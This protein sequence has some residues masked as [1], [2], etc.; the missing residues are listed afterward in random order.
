MQ[1]NAL[2]KYCKLLLTPQTLRCMKITAFIILAFCLHVSATTLAQNV[3]LSERKAPLEKVIND[4]KQQTGYAFFYN[5]DWM[6]QAQPVDVDVKNTSLEKVLE[7]CFANQPFRYNVINKTIVLKL[8]SEPE[9]LVEAAPITVSGK[10]TDTTGAPLPNA[11]VTIVGQN[12]ATLTSADGTFNISAQPGD[13]VTISFVGYASNSFIVKDGM[14]YQTVVLHASENKL[15]EVA[16]TVNT[17]YQTLPKERATGSF[18]TIDNK[19][20]NEEVTTNVLDR[21]EGN[22]P[23]LQFN[24]TAAGAPNVANGINATPNI[25]IRGH[26]TLFANDQPLIVVDDFPYDGN[27]SNIN[28]NDVESITVLKDAAA[29]SI[30]GVRSGNGVIVI[31]TKKGK[32]GQKMVIQFNTNVTVGDKPNLFYSPEFLDANDYINIEQKLYASGYY[33]S[34]LSKPYNLVTPA[35]QIMANQTAGT[36]SATDATN[37]LNALRNYDV[38]NDLTKYFLQKSVAQQYALSLLGGGDNSDYSLSLGSDNDL[39]NLV[40]NS[41]GRLTLNALYN[42]YPVKNLK[43]SVGINYVQTSAITDASSFVTNPTSLY[44]YAQLA[45]ANGNPLAISTDFSPIY[46]NSM[47]SLGYL[48]WQDKPLADIALADNQTKGIDNRINLGASYTFVKG[49]SA[50]IK[51]QYEKAS[52]VANNYYSDSTYTTRSQINKFASRSATGVFTYPIPVGGILQYSNGYLTSQDARVQFNF[53]HNW[54]NNHE[55]NAIAGADIRQEINESASGIAYGYDNSTGISTTTIDYADNFPLN[56]TGSGKITNSSSFSK[57]TN[58]YISYYSNASYTYKQRYVF[59]LSGRIDYSNLFGVNTNQKVVPLFSTGFAWSLDKEKFY[60][61]DWLPYLRPRVT[62]GYNANINTSATAV[63]TISQASNSTYS[64]L[65]FARVANPGNP[66]LTWEKDR[67]VNLAVDFEIQKSVLSGSIDYYLKNGINLFANSP[68]A[69]QTG[70]TTFFGNSADTKGHGVD[71]QLNSRNIYNKDF[72][73]TTSFIFSHVIDIVTKYN[74]NSTPSS[75]FTS[76]GLTPVVGAPV[77]ALYSYKWA[78]LSHTTGDPQGYIGNQ[79]S[80]NYSAIIS[81]ATFDSLQYNGP[82][83][84]TTFGSLRN[85]FSYKQFSLSFNIF[86]EFDFYFRKGSMWSIQNVGSGSNSGVNENYAQAWQKPGDEAFTNVP[87]IQYPPFNSNRTTFY[88]NSSILVDKG[89]NIRL[90]NISLSY[91]LT[92]AQIRH[93]PFSS[94]QLYGYANNI[95]I[96]WRANKDHLDP[97]IQNQSYSIPNPMS[98]SLGL[99]VNF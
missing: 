32:R 86:Y 43:L 60:H 92:K 93:L 62:Y 91:D 95:G 33:T 48:N 27:L 38:R 81:K 88:Q 79:P 90:G 10:V 82:S 11:T 4:I 94:L 26:S 37:Q 75:Y 28:P 25:S 71:I 76:A 41:N 2:C 66:D 16:I 63:T 61:I 54:H 36:I 51:Y 34:T 13:K 29:A 40:G 31:T 53:T 12:K 83:R 68:L 65:N 99:R 74:V 97:D 77:F 98:F 47:T 70:Q 87:S 5:A 73:W 50:D 6:K 72:K 3:T 35:V 15:S 14:P 24:H 46:K 57:S 52:T 85:T 58:N 64:G 21:L 20:F 19:L 49:L 56:P 80:T 67:N 59:S 18:A 8:K 17:G 1:L 39:S 78:G 42:F 30:W 45:D 69:P 44:P 55:V 96:L 22:V 23:G 84:P 7:L 89:D 9:K